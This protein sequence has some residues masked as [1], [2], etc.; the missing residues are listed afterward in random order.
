MER[1][2]SDKQDVVCPHQSVTCVHSRSLDYRQEISLNT[3][4]AD[5]R[6]PARFSSSDFIDL[7]Q[8]NDSGLL[9]SFHSQTGHL[10]HVDQPFL[11]ILEDMLPGLFHFDFPL[12]GLTT[13]E[14]RNNLLDM[15]TDFLDPAVGKNLKRRSHL[16]SGLDFDHPLI[17]QPL[18]KLST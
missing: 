11:F 15:D 6:A 5:F 3:L 13:Q 7:I 1:S 8:K 17:Q 9:H 14:S 12:F 2:S 4:S 16:L 10:V 18:A